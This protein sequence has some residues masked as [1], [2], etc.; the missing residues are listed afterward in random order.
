M[1]ALQDTWLLSQKVWDY[2]EQ[3]LLTEAIEL[4]GPK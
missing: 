1:N 3:Q 2:A 4:Q